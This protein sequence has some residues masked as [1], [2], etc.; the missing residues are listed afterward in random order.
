MNTSNLS[1]KYVFTN[2]ISTFGTVVEKSEGPQKLYVY[3]GGPGK[4]R[5]F[6]TCCT[7]VL[8]NAL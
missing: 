2:F 4:I 8:P 3:Q 6:F 1:T 7:K 5:G